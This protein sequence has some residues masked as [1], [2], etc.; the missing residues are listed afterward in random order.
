MSKKAKKRLMYIL[1]VI[2]SYFLS[3][4]LLLFIVGLILLRTIFNPVYLI[5]QV[6]NSGFSGQ[7]FNELREIYVSY[8]SASG[9]PQDVMISGLTLNQIDMAVKT[10]IRAAYNIGPPFNYTRYQEE[11]FDIFHEFALSQGSDDTEELEIALQDLASL[12]VEAFKRHNDSMF[13]NLIA[14]ITA[15]YHRIL[16]IVLF[17][18]GAFS[19]I[20]SVLIVVLNNQIQNTI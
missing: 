3:L 8:G 15:R 12:C 7:S 1:T 4:F 20:T 2:T 11:L 17:V 5:N 19:V 18:T 6:D 13:L 10:S 16:L 14:E 9:I